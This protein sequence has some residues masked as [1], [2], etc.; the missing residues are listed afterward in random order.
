MTCFPQLDIKVQPARGSM[1]AF[2]NYY[3]N[4]GIFLHSMTHYTIGDIDPRMVHFADEIQDD[5]RKFALNI[6]VNEMVVG[7]IDDD[8]NDSDYSVGCSL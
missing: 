1:L 5:V 6:W 3:E 4:G 2:P 7:V 8:E